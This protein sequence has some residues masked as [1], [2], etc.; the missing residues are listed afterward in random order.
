MTIEASFFKVQIALSAIALVLMLK[1][2]KSIDDSI[3]TCAEKLTYME[4]SAWRVVGIFFVFLLLFNW[5]GILIFLVY[6]LSD[7]MFQMTW[8]RRRHAVELDWRSAQA[9]SAMH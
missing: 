7:L 2:I 4:L 3:W 8:P 9:C 6:G 1:K 5:F